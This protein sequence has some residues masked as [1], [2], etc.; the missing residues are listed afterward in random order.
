MSES[1]CSR[2]RTQLQSYQ[3]SQTSDYRAQLAIEIDA[4]KRLE[5]EASR[6]SGA[7][8]RCQRESAATSSKASA[9][10]AEGRHIRR[11]VL[12]ISEQ[13]QELVGEMRRHSHGDNSVLSSG[14]LND[15]NDSGHTS[16]S[17]LAAA[18]GLRV[19]GSYGEGA[20]LIQTV[21]GDGV[22]AT[23]KS[24]TTVE[25]VHE[26]TNALESIRKTITWMKSVSTWNSNHDVD[27]KVRRLEAEN[28]RLVRE[29]DNFA[30]MQEDK[31][32]RL[33]AEIETLENLLSASRHRESSRIHEL[34]SRKSEIENSTA[35]DKETL[36][37]VENELRHSLDRVTELE[38]EKM[39]LQGEITKLNMTSKQVLNFPTLIPTLCFDPYL[40]CYLGRRNCRSSQTIASIQNGVT[41]AT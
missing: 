39:A 40:L 36:K 31:C 8:E 32:Q 9:L 22:L 4:R 24:S 3:D 7:L 28:A 16:G 20:E 35:R 27:G 5:V 11:C 38:S 30:S 18:L 41:I 37:K 12:E 6:I 34:D 15:S 17:L 29:A 14:P 1:E 2:L 13:L 23:S 25:G 21:D 10:R 33:Q 19:K 26:L